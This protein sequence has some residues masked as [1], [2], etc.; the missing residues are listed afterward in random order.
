M[1]IGRG[2]DGLVPR[3]GDDVWIGAGAKIFG[4][5]VI[6]DGCKVGAN[7]VVNR[8][9]TE[10]GRTIAGVPAKVVK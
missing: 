6:A 4:G 8:S 7:A 10:P 3:L 5:I 1:T 2:P 9:F